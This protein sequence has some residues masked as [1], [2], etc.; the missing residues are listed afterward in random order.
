MKHL[1]P[2]KESKDPEIEELIRTCLIDI[3]DNNFYV[4]ID[5]YPSKNYNIYISEGAFN[6][7]E[8]ADSIITMIEYL[9]TKG[10]KVEDGKLDIMC[11]DRIGN[12]SKTIEELD[13]L[14]MKNILRII[15]RLIEI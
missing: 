7:S 14:Q 11:W 9:K 5:Q 8:V 12:H 13:K 15:I 2:F 4:S 6:W 3:I 10:F 1:K